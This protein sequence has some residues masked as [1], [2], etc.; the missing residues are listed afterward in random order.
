MKPS[1]LQIN[2]KSKTK[3]EAGLPK[4]PI[5][6]ADVTLMGID[7]DF[8]RFRST[9]K[10]NDPK[11]ALLVLTTD[12]INELN[13]ED[14]PIKPGDLGENLTLTDI[15]YRSLAPKQK[16]AIGSTQIEISFICDPCSNLT[17]LPYVGKGKIKDFIKILLNRRGWY[18]KVLKAGRISKGDIVTKL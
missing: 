9:K 15:D 14:W 13:N 8:N 5:D 7:G 3:T 16:Y 11:M 12:I 4:V 6:K 18:A 17:V 2:K 10:A 1:V